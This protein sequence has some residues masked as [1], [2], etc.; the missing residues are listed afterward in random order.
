MNNVSKI[1]LVSAPVNNQVSTGANT[2]LLINGKEL[3]G[4]TSVNIDVKAGGLAKIKIEMLGHV[5]ANI[6]GEIET[7]I[8]PIKIPITE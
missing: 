5:Q 2:K 1:E 8:L 3:S 7:Q 4:V 6:L